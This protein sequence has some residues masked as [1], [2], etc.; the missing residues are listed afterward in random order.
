MAHGFLGAGG[1]WC[2]G[3]L[4]RGTGAAYWYTKDLAA[5]R[6]GMRRWRSDRLNPAVQSSSKLDRM[7]S[8]AAIGADTFTVTSLR[9]IDATAGRTTVLRELK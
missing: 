1:V 7:S 6:V 9:R 8:N 5:L 4:C 3:D 2:L